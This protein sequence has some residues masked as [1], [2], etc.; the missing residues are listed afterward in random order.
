LQ[1]EAA[2]LVELSTKVD[3]IKSLRETGNLNKISYL[4]EHHG[5]TDAT[6]KA[7]Y[8]LAKHTYECG[9]Y[10]KAS[11]YLTLFREVSTDSELGNNAIWGKL[12]TNILMEQWDV[13]LKDVQQVKEIV[14]ARAFANPTT[15]LQQRT[16][17]LHWSLPIFFN[18]PDSR[19][20]LLEFYHHE[21]TWQ[22]VQT[23][24][25]HLLRY[26]IVASVIS[27]RRFPKEIVKMVDQESY[28]YSDPVTKFIET[29]YGPSD[30]EGAEAQLQLCA[31]VLDND[32][33]LNLVKGDFLEA[34]RLL[35]FELF[36]KLHSCIDTRYDLLLFLTKKYS[37][38]S[39]LLEI[40][41]LT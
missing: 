27:K 6:L 16:W 23:S 25:P 37:R 15:Q 33:Y 4:Q 36:C 22:V 28:A 5:I 40:A 35:I 20:T 17:L 29:L 30:F 31:S 34:S 11:E 1:T 19:M 10:T 13:A 38:A 8:S 24:C 12:A 32:P 39:Y 41:L 21:K 2:P 7:F 9:D 3:V 18:S 14:E 26:I